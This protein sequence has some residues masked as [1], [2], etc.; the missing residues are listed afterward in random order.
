[1]SRL[2]FNDL[3][4]DVLI[5]LFDHIVFGLFLTTFVFFFDGLLNGFFYWIDDLR[6][7][8]LLASLEHDILKAYT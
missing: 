8:E 1:M 6:E 7:L 2:V 5:G 3:C 4:L